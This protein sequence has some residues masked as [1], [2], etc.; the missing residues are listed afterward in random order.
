MEWESSM[1]QRGGWIQSSKYSFDRS[2]C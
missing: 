2:V 1:K